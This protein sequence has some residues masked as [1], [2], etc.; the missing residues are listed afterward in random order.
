GHLRVDDSLVFAGHSS[1]RLV[2]DDPYPYSS[3][4]LD[5]QV[6]SPIQTYRLRQ[7]KPL[8]LQLDCKSPVVRVRLLVQRHQGL[9]SSWEI[10]VILTFLV[11]ER[12]ELI[13]KGSMD[14]PPIIALVIGL[15]KCMNPGPSL[16]GDWL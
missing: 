2:L 4:V 1:N 12:G 9:G 10:P 5:Y 8:E 16:Q 7:R 13:G 11:H 14:F 3:G 6:N 15:E